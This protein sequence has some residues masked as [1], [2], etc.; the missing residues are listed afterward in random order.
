MRRP[1]RKSLKNTG[2]FEMAAEKPIADPQQ[3][4][5]VAEASVFDRLSKTLDSEAATLSSD[6]AQ[7]E[8]DLRPKVV[9]ALANYE[10]DSS[11]VGRL[12]FDYRSV[13]KTKRKWTSLA[14]KIG[15]VI[16]CS[17]RTIYRMIDEYEDS[18][19]LPADS[20]V[21]FDRTE[22]D[23]PELLKQEGRKRDA[24][25]AIRVFLNNIPN[26]KKQ[27]VLAGLLAEEAYQVWGITEPFSIE[28]KPHASAFTIDGRKKLPVDQAGEKAA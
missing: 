23:G 24:R 14:R 7:R 12:L 22:I 11:E 28:V 19:A 21:S 17:E 27:E 26:N 15:R 9:A 8:K 13:Y 25:L 5:E 20:S 3:E 16:K 6:D 4:S 2:T 1:S 10:A 18:L